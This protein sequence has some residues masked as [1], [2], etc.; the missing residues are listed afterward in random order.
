[1]GLSGPGQSNIL[2]PNRPSQATIASTP[3]AGTITKATSSPV[4][5]TTGDTD[6]GGVSTPGPVTATGG[7]T[8]AVGQDGPDFDIKAVDAAI[9][10]LE[11]QF[12]LTKE[13]LLA[14]DSEIGRTYR[15][16]QAQA[17]R[18]RDADLESSVNQHI[19]R[20][21]L[22]SG[23]ALEDQADI[24]RDFAE[25]SSDLTSKEAATRAKI[26]SEIASAESETS[27]AKLAAAIDRGFQTL[28]LEELEALLEGGLG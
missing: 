1:M 24:E 25:L 12:N 2:T 16:L 20:G 18:G 14:D 21:I 13:Q 5:T 4:S 23:I 3:R 27:A 6:K 15:L 26:Q 28:T 17:L 10:A 9:K 7:V 22:R 19:E 8:G 11:A